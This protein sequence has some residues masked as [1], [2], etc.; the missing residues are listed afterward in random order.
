MRAFGV[1]H[2]STTLTKLAEITGV[3]KP[4]TH[5]LLASLIDAGMVTRNGRDYQLSST[6]LELAPAAMGGQYRTIQ[7]TMG[8]WLTRAYDGTRQSVHLAVLEG[9]RVVFIDRIPGPAGPRLQTGIGRHLPAHCTAL[10]K[11]ILAHGPSGQVDQ[12][13]RGRLVRMTPWSIVSP[14]G[15]KEALRVTQDRS[16]AVSVS[17]AGKDVACL[18][19]PIR[20]TEGC[21]RAALSVTARAHSFPEARFA[22]ILREVVSGV[23]IPPLGTVASQASRGQASLQGAMR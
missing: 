1:S 8:P 23:S 15:L 2:G 19:V 14:E 13:L 20:D 17:E 12:Y 11:A 22:G 9:S 7:D 3:S 5:R 16:Y 6:I 10:G 18:A 4:T 21:V